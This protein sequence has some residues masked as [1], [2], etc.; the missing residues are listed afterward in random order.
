MNQKEQRV[1]L[2]LGSNIEPEVNLFQAVN[3]LRQQVTVLQTSSVWES[4]AIGSDGPNFL[5]A[6]MLATTT[7]DAQNL[8]EQVLRPLEARLGRIRTEDKNAPRTIDIDLILFNQQL[9]D[10]C[11][12]GYAHSAVPVAELLPDYQ[13][14]TGE[15]LKDSAVSL[16][17]KTPITLRKDL[18]GYPFSTVFRKTIYKE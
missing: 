13:S 11:L 6:A 7:R 15:C 17:S 16:A 5:N 10:P 18:S 3:L 1:C 12:W 14:A 4:K 8:K 9:L 2:L